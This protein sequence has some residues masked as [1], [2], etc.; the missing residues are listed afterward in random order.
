MT[1]PVITHKFVSQ[2]VDGSNNDL[3]QPQSDWNDGHNIDAHTK[4]A[5]SALNSVNGKIRLPILIEEQTV[6]SQNSVT[7]SNLNGDVDIE[8]VLEYDFTTPDSGKDPQI[9]LNNNNTYATSTYLLSQN[10]GVSGGSATSGQIAW[11]NGALTFC[12]GKAE[13][14]AQ[15]GR[16]RTIS[17]IVHVKCSTIYTEWHL[18]DWTN[19]VDNITSIKVAVASSG[20]LTGTLRLYKMITIDLTNP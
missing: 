13:I 4:A 5:L 14:Y 12:K 1:D 7:F 19:T 9:Y 3:V 15:T 10:S 2:V 11:A 20:T 8:Y 6:T 18:Y 16:K 17:N